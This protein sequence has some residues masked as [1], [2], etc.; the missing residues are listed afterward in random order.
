VA[1]T[2]SAEVRDPPGEHFLSRAAL[3]LSA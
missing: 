1:V 3:P 2:P